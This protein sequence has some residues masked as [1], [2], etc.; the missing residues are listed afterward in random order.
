MQAYFDQRQTKH[1]PR[2]YFTQGQMKQ[3][4][5]IPDRTDRI[6]SGLG[7]AGISVAPPRD[8]GNAPLNRVHDLGYLRFLESAHRRW[9]A[10]GESWGDEVLSNIFVRS[11]NPKRGI[12]AEAGA[13]L[14]DGSCPVGEGTWESAYW[15]AQTALSAADDVLAGQP[16]AYALC[17]PPG[18]HAR[19]DAAGG[20][21]YLN[22][23]AIAAEALRERFPRIAIL[24]TDVHHGQGIQ[25]VFY[26]RSDV[27][28]LSIHGDPTNFYPVVAGFE[29]ER[30]SGAGHGTNINLPLPH[31]S[32]PDAFFDRLDE[33]VNAIR[34]FAPDALIFDNGF[35]IYREDPQAKVGVATADFERLG[36]RIAGLEL[37]TVVVQEGGYHL[38]SLTANIEHLVRGLRG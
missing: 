30:G 33:A 10:M 5:E 29:D 6:G 3:P 7:Q 34:L 38:D 20:F 12:L 21:C 13:Y 23:A 2:T 26:E 27:L 17:R 31:G 14:A 28:Y 19:V 9:K 1:H 4:Q 18:H 16:M 36:S 24:D 11:P 15:S 22:N 37:P 8:H 32:G 25:E 35:D